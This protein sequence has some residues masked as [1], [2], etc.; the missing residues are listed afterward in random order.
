MKRNSEILIRIIFS[1][2][3]ILS[4]ITYAPSKLITDS[5]S[6][7]ML[8]ITDESGE[9]FISDSDSVTG[10]NID[11]VDRNFITEQCRD[12][13]SVSQNFSLF[14]IF[15]HSIWQPPKIS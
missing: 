1:L 4:I 8:C 12:K 2:A 14:H 11:L 15:T 6:V 3:V 13:P 10:D 7:E 9:C 5:F